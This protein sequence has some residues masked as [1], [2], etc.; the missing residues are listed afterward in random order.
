MHFTQRLDHS[1]VLTLML[2]AG[3]DCKRVKVSLAAQCML[4]VYIFL[5]LRYDCAHSK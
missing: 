4:N 2:V 1:T 3:S 5:F